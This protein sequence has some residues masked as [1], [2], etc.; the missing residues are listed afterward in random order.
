MFLREPTMNEMN[1]RR[2]RGC[3]LLTTT[4]ALL[5]LAA[6]CAGRPSL[7]PNRDPALQKTS[8]QFAADAAKRFPYKSDVPQAGEAVARAQV[9]Y[10]MK[11]LDVVNLSDQDWNNVEIWVNEK[12][13][14]FL[15][16][17]KAKDF[18]SLPFEM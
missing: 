1:L 4:G 8:A 11:Y 13:V 7:V 2:L 5:T 3:V 16:Q 18:K 12:Y 14:V 6:G 10:A 15:P 17:M 9:R